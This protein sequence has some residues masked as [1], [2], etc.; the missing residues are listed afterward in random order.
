MVEYF[1]KWIELVAL[2]QNSLELAATTFLDRV[3]ARIGAPAEV[4]TNQGREF[5]GAFEEICMQA[6][7]DHRTMWHLKCYPL[8]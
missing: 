8:N 1:S 7:I 6:L 4:L 3:L 2:P 5:L